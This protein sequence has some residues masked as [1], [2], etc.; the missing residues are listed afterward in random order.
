MP[1]FKRVYVYYI[2]KILECQEG[3]AILLHINIDIPIKMVYNNFIMN[4]NSQKT[5]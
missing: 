3:I 5:K 4:V 1:P 2:P